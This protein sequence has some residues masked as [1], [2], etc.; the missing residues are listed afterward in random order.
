MP[1]CVKSG[2]KCPGYLQR[3]GNI[4]APETV[5]VDDSAST[6]SEVI[7]T[8][9]ST[10]SS[11]RSRLASGNGSGDES[12]EFDSLL[13]PSRH[14]LDSQLRRRTSCISPPL[15]STT[16]F[17][18]IVTDLDRHAWDFF[19]LTTY[20]NLRIITPLTGLLYPMI[21]LSLDNEPI[22]RAIAAAGKAQSDARFLFDTTLRHWHEHADRSAS[23]RQYGRALA[24]LRLHMLRNAHDERGKQVV[25]SAC[26]V[27]VCACL[28]D[29]NSSD[30]VTHLRLGLRIMKENVRSGLGAA[31][32]PTLDREQCL[33]SVVDES[34]RNEALV[35]L[36]PFS[37]PVIDVFETM[38]ERDAISEVQMP[39]VKQGEYDMNSMP[40]AFVNLEEARIHLDG[41]VATG[42]QL[43]QQLFRIAEQSLGN[44]ISTAL[45]H[46]V[47]TCLTT[48]MA[49]CVDLSNHYC[50]R[51]RLKQ[52]AI[53]LD[54]W[55][56]RFERF[57]QLHNFQSSR[58]PLL[59][60]IQHFT[61]SLKLFSLRTTSEQD[62]DQ[63]NS[64]FTST[65]NTCTEFLQLTASN[66]P[67]HMQ[68]PS[69]P[70]A[71][72]QHGGFGVEMRILPAMY[73]IAT[74]A[75]SPSL[76]A[77][78]VALLAKADRREGLHHSG[79]FGILAGSIAELEGEVEGFRGNNGH[80][81]T[82]GSMAGSNRHLRTTDFSSAV[83]PGR[84]SPFSEVL[85]AGNQG[86]PPMVQLTCGRILQ[87]SAGSMG[88]R[89]EVEKYHAPTLGAELVKVSRVVFELQKTM[90]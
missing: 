49:K 8:P 55:Q 90:V 13:A 51:S 57:A 68:D 46:N 72:T 4:Q 1:R 81:S 12:R 83:V 29:D 82:E 67:Y 27:L 52:L 19:H 62:Y 6:G 50:V 69:K 25:L 3:S 16:G 38:L 22:F 24:T 86:P 2:W 39:T 78:A 76:R 30:A 75:R 66:L 35:Q 85:I 9:T 88:P 70:R 26:L 34:K 17:Q 53:T 74:K 73:L 14:A 20:P 43:E 7:D 15:S 58:A 60:R 61:A 32:H 63:W 56:L 21:Q 65:L 48:C 77:R 18:F 40:G 36:G 54:S 45:H 37:Q 89:V 64:R 42:L 33:H 31:L 5:Q 79:L 28:L 44:I 23:S 71:E 11:S 84:I 47:F 59:M 41:L 80:L 10:S 87:T